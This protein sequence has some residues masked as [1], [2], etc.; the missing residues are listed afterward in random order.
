MDNNYY[1]EH[2]DETLSLVLDEIQNALLKVDRGSVQKFAEAIM[3]AEQVFF[4][5]VGRVMLSLE[6]MAKRFAHLGVRTHCVGAINE[7]AITDR[8]SWSWVRA[9]AAAYS[10]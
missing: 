10:P 8:I 4:I 9:A 1:S 3:E 7:P 6:A 2:F 5:G